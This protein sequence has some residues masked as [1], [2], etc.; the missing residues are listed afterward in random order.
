VEGCAFHAIV[1]GGCMVGEIKRE[2]SRSWG[3]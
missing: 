2:P 1:G 3:Y